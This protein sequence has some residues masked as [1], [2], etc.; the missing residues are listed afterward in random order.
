MLGDKLDRQLQILFKTSLI[1]NNSNIF[2]E[3]MQNN[4]QSKIVLL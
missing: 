1:T 4:F 2:F 3:L